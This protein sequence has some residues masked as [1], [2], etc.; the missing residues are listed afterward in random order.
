[1][2]HLLHALSGAEMLRVLNKFIE[3]DFEK[4]D[5]LLELYGKYA[6]RMRA[7]EKKQQSVGFA[8]MTDEDRYGSFDKRSFSVLVVLEI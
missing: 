6:R 2:C 1:M 4:V 7:V 3:N 8:D 5:R